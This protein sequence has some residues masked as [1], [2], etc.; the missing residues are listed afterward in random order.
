MGERSDAKFAI[1]DCLLSL[2]ITVGVDQLSLVCTVYSIRW[3]RDYFCCYFISTL[4]RLE[5]SSFV[6]IQQYDSEN[7]QSQSAQ[8]VF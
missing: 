3:D 1:T 8:D 5:C 2:D 6:S 7:D 4:G